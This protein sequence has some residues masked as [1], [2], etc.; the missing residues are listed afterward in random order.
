MASLGRIN[1]ISK[2][3]M[4]EER[5]KDPNAGV[6]TDT[7]RRIFENQYLD[8]SRIYSVFNN[9]NF[10]SI[11]H[12]QLA[13]IR[14]QS[15]EI[16]LIAARPPFIPTQ[17]RWSG[18]STTLILRRKFSMTT[19]AYFWPHSNPIFF[20]RLTRLDPRNN[21]WTVTSLMKQSPISI[22]KMWWNH[23]W[24]TIVYFTNR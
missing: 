21:Y 13:Y 11:P 7:T 10:S 15:S 18:Y 17:T 6:F 14:I 5:S 20:P 1:T 19:L 2:T 4:Q 9:D 23:G 3:S 12:D 16:H 22:T 24:K 8:W